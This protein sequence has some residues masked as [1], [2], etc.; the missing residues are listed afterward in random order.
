MPRLYLINPCNSGVSLV[1]LKANAL[2]KWRVWKPLGLLHLAALTPPDWEIRVLDENTGIPDYGALPAPDLV[3][4]TAFTSQADRAYHLASQF[5]AAGVP[6][7]MGGIHATM[8]PDEALAHVDA[9]VT[10]EAEEIWPQ[11]LADARGRGLQR[12][13]RGGPVDLQR[14]P[15]ARH[16]LLPTGYAFGS[17]Q[18]TRG[19][20]LDCSFCSVSAFNGKHYRLRPIADVV[21]EI[22]QIKEKFLLIVDDN[23]LGTSREHVARAKALFRAMIDAKIR[24]RWMAQLTINFA[25]DDELLELAARSGCFGVF[26]GFE[27]PTTAGLLELNKKFNFR[28]DRNFAASCHRIQRYGIGVLGSFI[29]G[30]DV[31][32]AGVGHQIADVASSYGVDILNLLFMTPLPGTRLWDSMEA[33]GRIAANEFPHDWRHYTLNLPVASHQHLSWVELFGEFGTCFRRFYSYPRI[34]RRLLAVL[35]R[36]KR[37]SSLIILAITNLIYRRNLRLDQKNFR[38]YDVRRGASWDDRALAVAAVPL[39][40]AV[41]GGAR[42][43]LAGGARG[44]M[45]VQ[46]GAGE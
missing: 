27:S 32:R 22:Q 14:V 9:I 46:P 7:V 40:L 11:M 6:V 19:C 41:A 2:N 36:P 23:L 38:A 44:A 34:L 13:Y 42:K 15:I 21:A 1:N 28:H 29:I 20:P 12:I 10:E 5:R 35:L 33:N 4:L 25:D 31:D 16:D 3:G 24:K 18:T 8:R 30:L 37:F 26:I 39:P 43:A 45:A 17:V